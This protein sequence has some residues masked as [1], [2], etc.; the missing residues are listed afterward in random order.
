MRRI[1]LK[2]SK[3]RETYDPFC[4]RN[5]HMW[6]SGELALVGRFRIFG[7]V[8]NQD[9]SDRVSLDRKCRL[10]LEEGHLA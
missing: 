10:E 1:L 7:R 5:D 8:P 4:A 2:I 9:A 3:K 6:N